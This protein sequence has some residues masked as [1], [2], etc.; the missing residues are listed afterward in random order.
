MKWPPE[1]L[2]KKNV[3]ELK[4]I[5]KEL[6]L[7]Q[8]GKKKDLIDKLLLF[9]DPEALENIE[10][11]IDLFHKKPRTDTPTIHHF[12]K[13]TFNSVDKANQNPFMTYC[14]G[15]TKEETARLVTGLMKL[16]L[17]NVRAVLDWKYGEKGYDFK[18]GRESIAIEL[19]LYSGLS[20]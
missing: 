12:Y 15:R 6:G 3:A 19:L 4:A 10:K 16:A 9:Q 1:V 5:C 7:K 13:A 2:E 17:T 14:P 20:V 8:N 11:T 18:H